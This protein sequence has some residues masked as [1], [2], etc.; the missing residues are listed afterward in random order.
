MVKLVCRGLKRGE[1]QVST[2]FCRLYVVGVDGYSS[3][4]CTGPGDGGNGRWGTFEGCHEEHSSCAPQQWNWALR[5]NPHHTSVHISQ[6]KR[7]APFCLSWQ[8]FFF[9]FSLFKSL[10]DQ[11]RSPAGIGEENLAKLIQ[12]ANIQ[13]DS[14]IIYNLQNLGCNIIAGVDVCD[15]SPCTPL[16]VLHCDSVCPSFLCQ[17]RNSGRTLPERKERTESTY[18]LSR[19]TPVIKDIMEVVMDVCVRFVWT[20]PN[21]SLIPC[22]RVERHRRQTGQEAV[23]IRIGSCSHQHHS[24]NSEVGQRTRKAQVMLV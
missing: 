23:A 17:G 15:C 14:N 11:T 10:C 5:Q 18:Q 20:A 4:C 8:F 12:H 3:V 13:N 7:S 2:T 21:S 19:W 9:N 6:E 16:A 24:D 1:R 22:A